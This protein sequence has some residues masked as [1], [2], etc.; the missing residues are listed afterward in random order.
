MAFSSDAVGILGISIGVRMISDEHLTNEA[1]SWIG[2][3]LKNSYDLERAEDWQRCLFA[4]AVRQL[5][6]PLDLAVPKS[7]AVADVRVA[8]VAKGL[9]EAGD[10]NQAVADGV[11][12]LRLAISEPQ[13]ELNWDRAALRLAAVESV[14][15]ATVSVVDGKGA[16]V[17]PKRRQQLS[18]RDVRVHDAVGRERF[19]TLTNAEIMKASSLKK[20]LRAEGLE[21]RGEATKRSF[22]RIRNAKGYPLSREIKEKRAARN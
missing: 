12:S 2:G 10:D 20:S 14:I 22:D 11:Q 13:D 4:A 19:C 21:P 5:G 1:I 8:L 6:S 17:S 18:D 15:E 7:A 3:F 9:M 16:T